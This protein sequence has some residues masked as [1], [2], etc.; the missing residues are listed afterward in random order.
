M[1]ILKQRFIIKGMQIILLC[2]L[3]S[4]FL[5]KLTYAS[6][7][8]IVIGQSLDFSANNFHIAKRYAAGAEVY[9]KAINDS[10]GINGHQIKLV[11]LDDQGSAA[12]YE[13]NLKTL[14]S[15]YKA[16]AI[17][18]CGSVAMC[19]IGSQVARESKIPLVGL[20]SGSERFKSN[21]NKY[22]FQIRPT[23]S[24]ESNATVAQL[25]NMGV[26][27]IAYLYDQNPSERKDTFVSELTKNGI[28]VTEQYFDISETNIL[29]QYQEKSN[30][31]QGYIFDI[32]AATIDKLAA[33]AFFKQIPIASVKLGLS[34]PSLI[35]LSNALRG[36]VFA[37]VAIVP[38]PEA[39]AIPITLEL[40][41][42]ANRFNEPYAVSFEGM[43]SYINIKT[44][45]GALR[46]AMPN[47]S[48]DR[49][50]LSLQNMREY[51]LGGLNITFGNSSTGGSSWLT[52]GL[53][54]A[55]GMYIK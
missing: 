18:N 28:S 53:R 45:I 8:A 34:D 51:D 1:L 23:Y 36:Q 31:Y 39:D 54:S 41:K 49:L 38:N 17:I 24:R 26:R 20:L 2:S 35:S 15:E 6:E 25:K 21:Q 48:A 44:C 22:V 40:Q 32:R 46:K 29:F 33:N 14:I 11:S 7:N 42:Y 55:K 27:N 10:G 3:L 16:I 19:A 5:L 30:T 13:K 52:I 4:L 37:F 43:E 50:T 12:K 9:V 47:Y